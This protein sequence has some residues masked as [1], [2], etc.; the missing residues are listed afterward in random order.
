MTSDLLNIDSIFEN[1]NVYQLAWN[2]G[3]IPV[4]V[5]KI[6]NMW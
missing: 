5:G 1:K 2:I 4:K 3:L 6:S